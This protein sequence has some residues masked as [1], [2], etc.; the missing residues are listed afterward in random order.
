VSKFRKAYTAA[1]VALVG[2]VGLALSDGSVTGSEVLV[3]LGAGLLAGA[4]VYK[5]PNAD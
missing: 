5:V 4:A 2:G 1:A 3:A